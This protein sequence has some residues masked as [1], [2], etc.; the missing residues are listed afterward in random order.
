VLR[1]DNYKPNIWGYNWAALILGEIN[2]GIWPSRLRESQIW[3]SEIWSWVLRDSK[4]RMT[5]LSRPS[6][7]VN[8]RSILSPER[9]SSVNK[10]TT[11]YRYLNRKGRNIDDGS[12]DACHN[13]PT[14]R[15]TIGGNIPLTSVNYM[16]QSSSEADSRSIC[17]EIFYEAAISSPCVQQHNTDLYSEAN[18]S[19]PHPPTIFSRQ[20]I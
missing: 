18:E 16:E 4:S 12:R 14:D 2:T 6:A 13:W 7:V 10:P 15:L 8:Y 1:T 17:W 3:V 11:V 5:A 19:S 9:V 20:L